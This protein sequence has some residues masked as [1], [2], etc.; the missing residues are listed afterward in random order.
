MIKKYPKENKVPDG[1]LKI[2]I[3]YNELGDKSNAFSSLNKLFKRF[4]SSN[5][6]KIGRQKYRQWEFDNE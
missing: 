1:V 6:A 5:T 3:S 2:A 4:P